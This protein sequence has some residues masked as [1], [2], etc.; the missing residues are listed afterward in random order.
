MDI[1]VTTKAL[2]RRKHLLDD[3]STHIPPPPTGGEDDGDG[4][5]TLRDLIE[6]VVIEQVRLFRERQENGKFIRALTEKEIEQ[7]AAKGKIEMGGRD[8]NQEVDTDDAIANA[9]QAFE[10]G[11]YLVSIDGRRYRELEEQVYLQPGSRIT[12]IRLVLL[13]GG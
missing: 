1:V 10:D 4:S 9:L 2:G 7:A 12:F 3:F 6:R 11:I 13:A 8:L 5:Y